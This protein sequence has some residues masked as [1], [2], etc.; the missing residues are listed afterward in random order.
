MSRFTMVVLAVVAVVLL[1]GSLALGQ[2]AT[3]AQP[4]EGH[5]H[6][7]DKTTQA[8][9]NCLTE[10]S[11]CMGHCAKLVENGQ[12]EHLMTMKLCDEC[13]AVCFITLK[14]TASRTAA[15]AAQAEACAKVCD[16]CGAACEKQPNDEM[17]KQCAQACRD[18]AKVCREM[19]TGSAKTTTPGR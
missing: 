3:A 7:R 18:C 4:K 6:H 5:A 16:V 12:K 10:C 13:A 9:V 2:N 17:M 15:L 8:L 11:L 1:T 14:M 19:R